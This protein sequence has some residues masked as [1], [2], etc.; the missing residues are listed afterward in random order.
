ML[1]DRKVEPIFHLRFTL[2][3]DD[4]TVK[5]IIVKKNDVIK[6][7][8]IQN[9]QAGNIIKNTIVGRVAEIA[10]NVSNEINAFTV[11]H[12]DLYMIVDG[13]KEYGSQKVYLRPDSI[14][15]IQI[16][17]QFNMG[18]ELPQDLN[19]KIKF[20]ENEEGLLQYSLDNGLEWKNIQIKQDLHKIKEYKPD[21]F[22]TSKPD[23]GLFKFKYSDSMV[24]DV[25]KGLLEASSFTKDKT[26]VGMSSVLEDNVYYISIY[27][28]GSTVL[29]LEYKDNT[30]KIY[31][32]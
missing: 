29:Q 15:D 26:Y 17:G 16:L 25:F 31:N 23:L 4:D 12:K 10:N 8:Y 30:W 7:V 24:G 13:S 19:S 3:Y 18:P 9:E 32:S 11:Y 20:K 2:T 14:L 1:I 6:C 28:N 5:N 22:D 27:G 21:N